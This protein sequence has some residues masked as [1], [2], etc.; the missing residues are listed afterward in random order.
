M[1]QM[2]VVP[3]SHDHSTN[4]HALCY[5]VVAHGELEIGALA[6]KRFE[7]RTTSHASGLPT[8][9]HL[10]HRGTGN[11]TDQH[12]WIELLFVSV[13]MIMIFGVDVGIAGGNDV[14]VDIITLLAERSGGNRYS[15][16]M[17]NT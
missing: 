3:A 14:D 6:G 16:I 7:R 8:P 13:Y 9:S 17:L 2:A 1:E 10:T 5:Q 15:R 12:S 4:K 11:V